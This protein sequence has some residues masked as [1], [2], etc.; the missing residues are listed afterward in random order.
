[1]FCAMA[2]EGEHALSHEVLSVVLMQ[3]LSWLTAAAAAS[4]ASTSPA[5]NVPRNSFFYVSACVTDMGREGGVTRLCVAAQSQV[6]YCCP[7]QK[8]RDTREARVMGGPQ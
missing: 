6:W 1:M 5:H 8:M 3:L 4:A 7:P 2:P